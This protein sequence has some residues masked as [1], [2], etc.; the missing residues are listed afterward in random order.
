LFLPWLIFLRGAGARTRPLVHV[1][2]CLWVLSSLGTFLPRFWL[3]ALLVLSVLLGNSL[4]QAPGRLNYFTRGLLM[5]GLLSN[6]TWGA[7]F[8]LDSEGLKVVWG[9]KD[10]A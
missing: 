3:L 2:V 7:S 1:L 6:W 9:R 4:T 10:K 8:I 5:I